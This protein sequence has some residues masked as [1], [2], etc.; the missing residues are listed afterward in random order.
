M[1]WDEVDEEEYQAKAV[2][3]TKLVT[4][5]SRGAVGIVLAPNTQDDVAP[6]ESDFQDP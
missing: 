5:T 2:R 6:Q 3:L 1:P 4:N